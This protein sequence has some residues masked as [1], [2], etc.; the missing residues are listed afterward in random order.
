MVYKFKNIAQAAPAAQAVMME[1]SGGYAHGLRTSVPPL[2]IKA[3]ELTECINF[4][5]NK[6]GQL[7][8][9]AGLEKLNTTSLGKILTLAACKIGSST[10]KLIQTSDFVIHKFNTDGTTTALGTAEGQAE[11]I[12]YG[13]YAIVADGGR[14]KYIDS[15]ETL[16]MVW[17]GGDGVDASFFY[18]ISDTI[19]GQINY[20]TAGT[21]QINFTTPAWTAGYTI[22]LTKLKVKL[23][24]VG[25]G[26][27]G[28]PTLTVYRTSDNAVMA[29]GTT[30]V[31]ASA[32]APDPGD[33]ED[34]NLTSV[35][36][37]SPNTAYYV[38]FSM[39][40]YSTSNY[41]VWYTG[42]SSIP[43]CK[44]SP[45]LAPVAGAMLVHNRQLWLYADENNR[46]TL[47][48]NNYAPF[49]WSTPGYAG[50]LTTLDDNKDSYPIGAA[51]SFYGSLYV[52]GT[53][54]WPYFLQ[55]TGTDGSDFELSDLHQ[56]L[57]T[58]PRMIISALNDVWSVSRG[59]VASLSGVNLFGDVR[60]Y[61]E[62][63]AIDNQIEALWSE[64]SKVGYHKER[65]QLFV[66]VGGK[67]FVAHAKSAATI[68]NEDITHVRYPW[69]EYQYNF[70][71]SCLGEWGD[72][73]IGSEEGFIYQ[74]VGT[75]TK[76]DNTDFYISMKT[77]YYQTPFRLI[78][79]LDIK[80]LIDTHTGATFDIVAYKDNNTLTEVDRWSL[81]SAIHDG[82]TIDDLGDAVIDDL[83]SPISIEA[84]PLVQWLG[85]TCFAYQLHLDNLKTIG[86]PV[87]I[88]GLATRYRPMED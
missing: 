79:V 70:T 12:S 6:G 32:I 39:T 68:N 50:Y 16:K 60:T 38:R 83:P 18:N 58:L 67:M 33:F 55:L 46:G 8:T 28:Y 36:E 3:T 71:P 25:T 42:A 9:R 20:T 72:L 74:P 64:E 45:G 4:Q 54:D 59:G 51:V 17:D 61:S 57:W 88:D 56:P 41:I 22:P 76:D 31:A 1:F 47:Y 40:S 85:F 78:D 48:F 44:V 5:I 2:M 80:V 11:I 23:G 26:G 19:T 21:N 43:I 13:G 52:Y 69:S 27:A 62:S 37:V 7:Q 35:I 75:L 15:S 34:V 87:H 10:F 29:H 86:K 14:L 24:R 30:A 66:L 53:E 63:F 82:A 77:K 49:D 84:T 81:A 73:V 65:G